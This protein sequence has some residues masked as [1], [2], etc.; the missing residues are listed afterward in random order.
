MM[1]IQLLQTVASQRLR[2]KSNHKYE[3]FHRDSMQFLQY[4][5]SE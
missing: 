5:E 4:R 3:Y 1:Q 2:K